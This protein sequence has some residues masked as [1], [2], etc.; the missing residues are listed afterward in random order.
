MT[1]SLDMPELEDWIQDLEHS[2]DVLY[3]L[4]RDLRILYCNQAWDDFAA[5]NEGQKLIRTSIL[6][7]SI[8]QAIAAPLQEFYATVFQYVRENGQPFELEYECSSPELFRVFHMRVL[9]V[10][11]SQRLL[12]INSL[13]VEQPHGLDRPAQPADH[14][15]YTDEYGFVHMCSHCRHTRRVED[16]HWDWVPSYLNQPPAPVSHGLCPACMVY[17]Y[18]DQWK[19]LRHRIQLR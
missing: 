3:V 8:L 14:A 13:A 7:Q 18:P 10:Q 17:F 5:Q 9:P 15:R 6:G 16:N 19:A 12:M 4:D 11:G 2:R 1:D